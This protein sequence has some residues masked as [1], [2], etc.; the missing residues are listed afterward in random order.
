LKS[1]ASELAGNP[2][3]DSHEW[4][5]QYMLFYNTEAA[6]L[7]ASIG[8]GILRA[9]DEPVKEKSRLLRS[10]DPS[11]EFL[12][13]KSAMYAP[14]SSS[15]RHY[16][17]QRDLYCHASSPIRRFAD[18]INQFI[19]KSHLHS[20]IPP[21]SKED[22]Q[23][24]IHRLNARQKIIASAERDFAFLKA[25]TEA[26]TAQ[27]QGT[28]LWMEEERFQ[29]IWIPSWKTILRM[30]IKSGT[31]PG[32]NVTITYFCDRRKAKWKERLIATYSD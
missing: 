29:F 27:L 6:K 8:V 4:I 24:I 16:G 22:V 31:S 18:F 7:L 19:I 28:V 14:V 1:I 11:L 15:T 9:H 26:D 20:T 12:A 25:I 32:D 23:V 13:Y 5:E 3:T 21:F 30:A 10:I 17:L 2:I